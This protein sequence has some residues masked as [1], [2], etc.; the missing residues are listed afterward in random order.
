MGPAMDD[1]V[2]LSAKVR[3]VLILAVFLCDITAFV[4]IIYELMPPGGTFL[5]KPLNMLKAYAA[6]MLLGAFMGL[7]GPALLGLMI[8]L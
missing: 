6:C 5:D 8:L 1:F 4:W 2:S 3:S 7:L